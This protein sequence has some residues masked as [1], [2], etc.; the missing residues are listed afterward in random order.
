MDD[1]LHLT[2]LFS[3]LKKSYPTKKELEE[4][5]NYSIKE[6]DSLNEVKRLFCNRNR[7]LFVDTT[8]LSHDNTFIYCIACEEELSKKI[9]D[10]ANHFDFFAF[11]KTKEYEDFLIDEINFFAN[12]QQF[13]IS[14]KEINR[15]LKKGHFQNQQELYLR[16]LSKC[17]K[18][19]QTHEFN[20][21]N[22]SRLYHLLIID[23]AEGTSEN[24]RQAGY[25]QKAVNIN[26]DMIPV[27]G[28]LPFI[29][30]FQNLERLFG[31]LKMREQNNNVEKEIITFLISYFYFDI[32]YP[33]PYFHIEMM[34][35]ISLWMVNGKSL[36]LSQMIRISR[37]NNDA[38]RL[39]YLKSIKN[40]FEMNNDMSYVLFDLI[41]QLFR[42]LYP[43]LVADKIKQRV[44][45]EGNELSKKELQAIKIIAS[46]NSSDGN[47]YFD[48]RKYL[49]AEGKK[50]S[51][52]YALRLLND[53]EEKGILIAKGSH[54]KL[55]ALNFQKFSLP[56]LE[57]L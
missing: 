17:L 14:Q 41:G 48:W 53:L 45:A 37:L 57:Q 47:A 9:L 55:F 4:R 13:N 7:H 52:Q 25:R 54:Y 18:F 40:T 6:F 29:D 46:F 15:I 44:L 51:K 19:I 36:L 24:D 12:K 1:N 31:Y 49:L 30:I 38:N 10:F 50:M 8:L 21:S 32:L 23:I 3:L 35:L 5:F 28:T 27:V 20:I 39:C 43:Q 16:N 42:S 56:L 11:S 22:I 26:D 2:Q 34:R 33:Y